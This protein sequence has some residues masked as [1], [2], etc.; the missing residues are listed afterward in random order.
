[1]ILVARFVAA[2]AMV[3]AFTFMGVWTV[4]LALADYRFRQ[5]TLS[6]TTAALVLEPDNAAYFVRLAAIIQESNPA[7]S[8]RALQRAIALNASDSQSW[9]ELGLRAEA[10]GDLA[11][12][13]SSLLRA[14]SVDAEYY[15]RWS[16]VNY[17]FRHGNVEKF[18]FW[19]RKA[20]EM[21]YGD[22]APLFTLCWNVA[23]DGAF[24]E[25]RLDIR[26]AD[27]EADYLTYLTSQNR[28]EPMTQAAT[29]LLAWNREG[30]V[31]VLLAACERLI[32]DDR[33]DQAIRIWNKLA[34][35]HRILYGALAPGLG[36]SLTDGDFAIL[37]TSR[38]F[39]WQLPSTGGITALLDERSAGLWIS[40]SGRQLENCDALAQFLPV[41]EDSNYELRFLYR[42]SGIAS[43]TGL[44]WRITSL[45]ESRVFAQGESLA[46]D[47]EKE[48]R[49]RFRTP[50]GS[51]MVRLALTYH[52]TLGTTRIEGS[53]VLRR[54]R[55]TQAQPPSPDS[56][57][58]AMRVHR[59]GSQ[60]R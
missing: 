49:L 55:L 31:P 14:A 18:W 36:T 15:P 41:V 24:I 60:S 33:P 40:F 11:G 19:A 8:V 10:A 17:Y 2:A 43:G 30:D 9:I 57:R 37:P 47:S 23:S 56:P 3:A 27:V 16:L 26:K 20:T 21:A 42:T 38:G 13:E 12:A 4:R 1:M 48:S 28:V 59:M 7:G 46:S 54:L 45:N 34:E 35:L 6:G 32:A 52:R 25:Q 22:P 53:I 39:D 51:G 5:E 29:R 50:T 58:Q 44:G